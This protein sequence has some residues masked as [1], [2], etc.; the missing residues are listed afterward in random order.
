MFASSLEEVVHKQG[1]PRLKLFSDLRLGNTQVTEQFTALILAGVA[2]VVI[3]GVAHMGAHRN[4]TANLAMG[5]PFAH[6]MAIEFADNSQPILSVA[7]EQPVSEA[8]EAAARDEF[9]MTNATPEGLLAPLTLAPVAAPL[10]QQLAAAVAP[11]PKPEHIVRTAEIGRK[12]SLSGLLVA[13]ADLDDSEVSAVTKALATVYK[14]KLARGVELSMRF[15]QIGDD[16]T[17]DGLSF[18]PDFTTEVRVTRLADGSFKA[19]KINTPLERQRNAVEGTVRGSLVESGVARGVPRNVMSSMLRAFSHEVDFQRDIHAGDKFRVLYDQP[20][21]KNGQAVGDATII[22]AA[23]EGREVKKAVYRVI[24]NDGTAEYF[25][26]RGEGVRRG[27]MR[28]PIDGA[29]VTSNYGMRRHPIL[30]YSKFHQG[31]DFAAPAGTPIFAAGDG[32]VEEA[33]FHG[34]YGRFILIKHRNGLE[35]AYGH[36]SR[37]ARALREGDHVGQG[38]VIGY[39][40]STGRSTGPHLHFEVRVNDAPVNPLSVSM[41]VGSQLSGKGMV[42]FNAG[43]SAIDAEFRRRAVATKETPVKVASRGKLKAG[44]E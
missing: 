42:Q 32:V 9:A 30:G 44:E 2:A 18:Q 35:T 19:D 25:N 22:Y 33:G 5:E 11:P 31:V 43:K 41:H 3:G 13:E 15:T 37:F 8:E 20:R 26:D 12:G 27:L 28:T 40:G 39:V 14:G 10:V 38:D 23:I 7:A 29:H 34:S 16:E 24:Y 21:A 4:Q 36:M 6:D 17:F 1:W